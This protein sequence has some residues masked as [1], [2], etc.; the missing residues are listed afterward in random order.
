MILN[1]LIFDEY[2]LKSETFKDIL[3]ILERDS[4]SSSYKFAL[5]RATIDVIQEQSPFITLTKSKAHMPLGLII[6]KWIFYYYPLFSFNQKIVQT[7][8]KKLAFQDQ[9]LAVIN[10]YHLKGGLSKCYNDLNGRGIEPT[11]TNIFFDLIRKLKQTIIKQ[12]MRYIG[13]SIKNTHYSIYQAEENPKLILG[14]AS[15]NKTFLIQQCGIISIPIDYYNAFDF[16]GMFITGT[17]SITN[18]WTNYSHQL[19]DN[20]EKSIIISQLH[21]EPVDERETS[22]SKNIFKLLEK[23]ITINCVWTGAKCNEYDLDHLIPFSVWKNNNL[24]N[25]LPAKP[26][27]NNAKKDKIPCKTAL[28]KAKARILK[29]WRHI[30]AVDEERLVNELF[31]DLIGP[32]SIQKEEYFEFAFSKLVQNCEHLIS[33]RGYEAWSYEK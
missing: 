29:Y 10:Y 22:K 25:V 26:S 3:S 28:L 32:G 4:K 33:F 7:S 17:K 12:P 16:I 8:N 31:I 27:V 30:A 18:L 20:I 6:Q 15:I 24:W 1:P 21:Q 14:K 19:S 23:E 9:I 5:I 13:G 2:I 11:A